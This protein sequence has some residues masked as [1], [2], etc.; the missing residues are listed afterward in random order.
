M[1]WYLTI[2]SDADYSR[3]TPT[4]PL[5]EFVAAISELRQ[6][7]PV[8]F[9]AAAGQPWVAVIL[10]M[11]GPDGSYASDGAFVPTINVVEL[12]CSDS[13]DPMW[14]K[15]LASRIAMFLG[16]SAFEDREERQI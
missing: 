8:T 7:G 16:W 5:V 3:F 4:A 6:T 15:A 11:C 1:S 10:A 2:R 14:Y 12:V 9:E 13:A